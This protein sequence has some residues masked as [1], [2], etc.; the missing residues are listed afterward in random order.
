MTKE[1]QA[2][3]LKSCGVLKSM[4]PSMQRQQ[5]F[6]TDD[7]IYCIYIDEEAVRQHAK[8]G[9]FPANKA[10]RVWRMIDPTTAEV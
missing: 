8:S 9:D 2:I 6:V 3:S 1:L 10:A 7:R 5:S 4:G